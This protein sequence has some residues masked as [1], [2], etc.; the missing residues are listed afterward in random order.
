M[1]E[2][3]LIVQEAAPLELTPIGLWKPKTWLVKLPGSGNVVRVRTINLID[4][5]RRGQV[6]N[7]LLPLARKV[8]VGGGLNINTIT[9]DEMKAMLELMA[10]I[11]TKCIVFPAIYDGEGEP[12]EG[13]VPIA[14]LSQEDQGA[15]TNW[16]LQ[17][18][19]TDFAGFREE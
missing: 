9:D 11:V 14:W 16:A 4:A 18:V 8:A 17:G 7:T 5:I 2:E 10:W 19:K 6:P 12:P 15:I 13:S 1:A 3:E